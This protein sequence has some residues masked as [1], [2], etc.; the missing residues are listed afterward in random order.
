MQTSGIYKISSIVHP[1]RFYIGS[2]FCADQRWS[3][4]TRRLNRN[5]HGN[6]K[7]QH[8]VNK[9]GIGDLAFN[10][11]EECP[12]ETLI[13]REQYYIDTLNPWFNLCPK[14]G[15][16]LGVK[17]SDEIKHKISEA[18]KGKRRSEETKQK[19]SVKRKLQIPP[20]LGKKH[21]EETKMLMSEIR[22]NYFINKKNNVK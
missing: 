12:I 8:H 20:M 18:G 2:T 22:K 13:E 14:A 19:M 4:H 11:I 21:S 10:I 7:L 17:R 16:C 6:S 5:L 3:E 9:Y 15:S 1:E